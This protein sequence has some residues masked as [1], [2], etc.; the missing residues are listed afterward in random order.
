MKKLFLSLTSLT[1]VA[2]VIALLTT[3]CNKTSNEEYSYLESSQTKIA[4]TAIHGNI[5]DAP[6]YS[7][8]YFNQGLIL[9]CLH[10]SLDPTYADYFSVTITDSTMQRLVFTGDQGN[11]H[12]WTDCNVRTCEGFRVFPVR[13]RINLNKVSG[14]WMYFN[15]GEKVRLD[16]G[17]ICPSANVLKRYPGGSVTVTY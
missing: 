11:K 7:F 6:R 1:I 16:Y 3:Q 2:V 12:E 5:P 15:N 10:D 13:I 9:D 17:S 4:I 14:M 8:D